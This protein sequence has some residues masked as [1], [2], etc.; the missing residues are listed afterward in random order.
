MKP[1]AYDAVARD[2][3]A[4]ISAAGLDVAP[5]AAPSACPRRPAGWPGW[6]GPAPRSLVPD[7]MVQLHGPDLDIL[8]YPMDL[9]ISGSASNVA[10]ARAAMASRLTTSA[11]HLTI[12]AEAQAIE[13][14][15]TRL[16][17]RPGGAADQP[18]PF[19]DVARREFA[20]IDEALARIEIPYDEWEVLYR[21]RLQ[22][23]RDLRAGAMAGEAVLGAPQ[24]DADS[25]PLAGPLA[26]LAR[27]GRLVR[28]G[29]TAVV[30]AAGDPETVE[31]LDKIGGRS[32]GWRCAPHRSAP[33]P[34]G[35]C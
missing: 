19:D 27:V 2:L 12:S 18:A 7:R 31:T 13:D 28:T 15:L 22:V 26:T 17:T 6:P 23:E 4:A 21:Q 30:E 11:A 32:G 3:D 14:R 8:I 29:A 1:G 16:A 20:E 34:S 35:P 33:R 24:P 9:L 10:R 25:N 5:R